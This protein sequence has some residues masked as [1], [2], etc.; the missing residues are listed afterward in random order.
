VS[1]DT[2]AEVDDPHLE[3]TG[4]GDHTMEIR[5]RPDGTVLVD[6]LSGFDYGG[7]RFDLDNDMRRLLIGY[8]MR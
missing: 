2:A 7:S 3:F 4:L 6:V 5:I 1:G 8:L